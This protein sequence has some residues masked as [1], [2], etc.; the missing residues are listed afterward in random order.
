MAIILDLFQQQ[1]FILA[2][3]SVNSKLTALACFS[4]FDNVWSYLTYFDL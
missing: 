2:I 4:L 1:Y 3:T